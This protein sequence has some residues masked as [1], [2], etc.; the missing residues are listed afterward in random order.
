[1][2]HHKYFYFAG[3]ILLIYIACTKDPS[4]VI[5][6]MEISVSG[7]SNISPTGAIIT[8]FIKS[9]G[10]S[11]ISKRGVC[12]S[13]S[14]KP[15]VLNFLTTSDTVGIG[16]FFSKLSRL[17]PSTQ[18]YV[19][20]YAI[21][22]YGTEYSNEINF[23]TP[24]ISLASLS[25]TSISNITQ[26]SAKSGGVVISN[27]GDSITQKG[28]CWGVTALPMISDSH[29]SDGAGST[30]FPSSITGLTPNTTYNVRAYATNSVGTAYGNVLNLVSSPAELPTISTTIISLIG[31]STASSGGNISADGGAAVTVRGVCWNTT[32]TPTIANSITTDGAGIGSYSSSIAGL[33]SGTTYYVRAY[34]TNSIGTKYGLEASF[35]TASPVPP[36]LTTTN[37]SS[38]TLTTASSGGNIANDGGSAVTV[39][40]VCWN[41]TGAPTIANSSTTNGAGI[42]SYSSSITGLNS[43]TTYY[44]RAYATNSIGGTYYGNQTSFIT[45]L[46]SLPSITSTIISQLDQTSAMSGGNISNDGGAAVT[47]RGVC[48]NTTG[49]PTIANSSTIDGAGI[50]SYSSSLTGL[51]PSTTYYM[52]AYATNSAGPNY[53]SQISFVTLAYPSL[54]APVLTSPL[55]GARTICCYINYSWTLITGATSYEFQLSKNSLFPT[56]GIIT[57]STCGGSSYPLTTVVNS[58]ILSA[59]AFC[60]NGGSSTNNGTWY[61][62]VR[63]KNSVS[64]GAWSSVF[65]HVY[66]W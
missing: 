58:A 32:G 9:D 1:M 37:V 20:A 41:T 16:N 64:V 62:R 43:G 21:N 45:S 47:V 29:T 57:I 14:P 59:N 28:V 48:W 4:P 52:K 18:Y 3:F 34:A 31:L 13:V 26:R 2:K 17:L 44:V 49:S 19:R 23:I 27:G 40:G 39:R 6:K 7:S 61:W 38:I 33:T 30:N 55:N 25:T 15:S 8:S 36:T 60:V 53:G 56:S 10:G 65:T 12:Y 22:D 24:A 66:T 42:G 46:P 54:T 63:A 50:G 5:K 51:L 11:P 35:T